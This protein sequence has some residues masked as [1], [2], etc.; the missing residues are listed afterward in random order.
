MGLTIWHD[1]HDTSH[2]NHQLRPPSTT[3]LSLMTSQHGHR[4][5]WPPL[6][7]FRS[8]TST[9]AT[10]R[11]EDTSS[12]LSESSLTVEPANKAGFDKFLGQTN[13]QYSPTSRGQT[14]NSNWPCKA[15]ESSS[16]LH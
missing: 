9:T 12:L 6:W 14:N 5:P 13:V 11:H 8:R 7:V 1:H 3:G 4:S 15:S 16:F 2:L 10:I